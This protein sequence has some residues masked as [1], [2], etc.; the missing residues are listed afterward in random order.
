MKNKAIPANPRSILPFPLDKLETYASAIND[1]TDSNPIHNDIIPFM[2]CNLSVNITASFFRFN[3][4]PLFRCFS[5][6]LI[7]TA[8]CAPAQIAG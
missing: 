8:I 3:I 7:M 5:T 1:M 4:I 2:E 6:I